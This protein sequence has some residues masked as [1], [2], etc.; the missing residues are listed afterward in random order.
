MRLSAWVLLAAACSSSS[1]RAT[2]AARP[3]DGPGAR[4]ALRAG[5]GPG[6]G[7]AGRASDAARSDAGR[8]PDGAPGR[9]APPPLRDGPR[10][11][12]GADAAA[13]TDKC[14][15]S[16]GGISWG[17]KRRFLYGLNYAWLHFG[18][19]FGGIRAF[20]QGGV[21]A[22]APA[23]AANLQ[24]MAS[25]GAHT[26]RWWVFPDFRGDGVTFDA[27]DTPTGLGPTAV[28]DLQKALEL[29]DQAGVHVALCLFSF[30]G[31][32]PTADMAGV[33]IRGLAPIVRDPG[34]RA[35]LLERVVRPLA[36]AAQASPHAER[37]VA[38]DV[39]NEPEWAMTGPSPYGD[40]AYDPTPGLE[41]LPHA[42]MEG[43]VRD[44]STALRAESRALVTVGGAAPKWA[45]AWTGVGVDFYQWHYYDWI[46]RYWPYT[47]PPAQYGLDRPILI[48]EFP[49]GELVAGLPFEAVIAGFYGEGYAGGWGWQFVEAT[50]AQLADVAA[51]GAA[52]P[53]DTH[54][55]AE[56]AV[57]IPAFAERA[58]D[59][60]NV[61]L[62]TSSQLGK[63]VC[64]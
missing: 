12:A 24:Q 1:G 22:E 14:P 6:R 32:R 58:P 30:D 21:A 2:D 18:G 63:P 45:H 4:D 31:F 8:G 17:C 9:D 29:A 44:V 42:E 10:G 16:A 40:M 19:D 48:G 64:R 28:A 38:W 46:Q 43:F 15:A 50:A 13:C 49:L 53:C 35:A 33:H 41:A 62:C 51:F 39:I 34:K 27:T 60:R 11:D 3:G 26:V 56:A 54:L 47:T 55:K 52:H 61:R 25:R 23:H 5:D 37:L 36:R 59:L 7:D 57:A 20:N